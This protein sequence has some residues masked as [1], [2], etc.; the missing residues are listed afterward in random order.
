MS[1][2]SGSTAEVLESF[3]VVLVGELSTSKV[4]QQICTAS[5]QKRLR[6]RTGAEEA[7]GRVTR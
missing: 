7:V 3:E 2:T 5:T 6:T 4:Q 1:C